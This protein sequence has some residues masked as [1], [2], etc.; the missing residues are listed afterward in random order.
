MHIL[1]SD[2]SQIVVI[3]NILDFALYLFYK[4]LLFNNTSFTLQFNISEYWNI[5][6]QIYFLCNTIKWKALPGATLFT[7]WAT[8]V[9]LCQ[10]DMGVVAPRGHGICIPLGHPGDEPQPHFFEWRTNVFP[11]NHFLE[12][13]KR[14]DTIVKNLFFF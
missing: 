1:S 9:W 2:M 11:Y 12:T 13:Q 8:W 5:F 10:Q 4:L 7:H 14:E 3:Q 6:A